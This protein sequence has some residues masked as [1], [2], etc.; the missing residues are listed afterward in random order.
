MAQA[1]QLTAEQIF[2]QMQN[3][4]REL[5]HRVQNQPQRDHLGRTQLEARKDYLEFAKNKPTFERG[6]NRW[7]DFASQFDRA[8]V[9]YGVTEIQAKWVLYNAIVGQSSRLV[10]TSMAPDAPGVEGEPFRDYLRRMGEKFT[11]AAESLQME[12]EYRAR[13]QAKNEDVQN[14]IN[15]KYELFQLSNPRARERDRAEFYRECTEGFLNKYV[16][17]QMFSYEPRDI[18]QFGARAV[19]LVQIERRRIRIGDSETTNL[20]G[21]IPVTKPIRD[22]NAKYRD[23]MME[24]D[25]MSQYD[26][27]DEEEDEDGECECMAMQEHGFRGTCYYCQKQGHLL[28]SCPRKSAGLPK[29]FRPRPEGGQP[30]GRGRPYQRGGANRNLGNRGGYSGTGAKKPFQKRDGKP[31]RGVNQVGEEPSEGGDE[32]QEYAEEEANA[33]SAAHFLGELTL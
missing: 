4:L 19:T 11:P 24:V 30:S 16:R 26:Q 28:R 12:A 25:A 29:V 18:E 14:Y 8:R 27:G 3:R 20:D 23:D 33:E 1:Q 22:E 6:K 5:E 17:D 21:L 31:Q 7:V 2:E 10:I 9:D 15:A 32:D 13:K